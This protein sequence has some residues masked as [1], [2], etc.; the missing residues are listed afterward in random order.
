MDD[1]SASEPGSTRPRTSR[2]QGR[3]NIIE[4]TITLLATRTPD[5]I[6][7]RQIAEESGHHHRMV[8]AWFGGKIPLFLA[9]HEQLNEAIAERWCNPLGSVDNSD[10]VRMTT[11]LMNWL[12]AADPSV[13][14]SRTGTPILD[15][16]TSIYEASYGLDPR[17]ARMMALRS[18]AGSITATLFP[19]PL[20]I[21][22]QDV[23]ELANFE[24]R[25]VQLLAASR[26]DGPPAG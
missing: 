26:T 2:T 19:G 22:D 21:S 20:G 25:L 11:A 12:I 6:T 18:V 1:V 23:A 7:V 13:F 8:Q 17:D 4:A 5:E 9:V 10:L 15:Q 14:E 24:E 3:R 16:L